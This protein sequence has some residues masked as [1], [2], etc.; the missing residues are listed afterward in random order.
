MILYYG[1]ECNST[2]QYS[3]PLIRTKGIT[4]PTLSP[5]VDLVLQ[6]HAAKK[7]LETGIRTEVIEEQV[8]FQEQGNV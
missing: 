7:A 8:R 1:W 4:K 2:G 6:S 5:R 3:A